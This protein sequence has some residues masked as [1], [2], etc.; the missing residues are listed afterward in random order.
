MRDHLKTQLYRQLEGSCNG[1]HGY[2]IAVSSLEQVDSGIVQ[3]TSGAVAFSVRCRT[4]VLKPYKNEVLDAKIKT[5]NKMGFFAMVG[6]LQIFVS[7]HVSF[8]HFSQSNDS[9]LKR[10]ANHKKPTIIARIYCF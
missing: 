2:I 4:V 5:V 1:R 7:S 3:E 8:H 6:P 9:C 10:R